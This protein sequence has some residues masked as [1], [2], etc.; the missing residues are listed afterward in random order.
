MPVCLILGGKFVAIKMSDEVDY[1]FLRHITVLLT[2]RPKN[3]FQDRL[4]L[5]AG[6][7]YCRMLPLEHSAILSTF[8]RLPFFIKTF[9]LS[10]DKWPF[11]T[12]F[13]VVHCLKDH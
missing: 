8:I 13:T 9:A 4:S 1:D 7:K 6:Q 3:G 12:G 10:I 11:Y 2:K 5:N